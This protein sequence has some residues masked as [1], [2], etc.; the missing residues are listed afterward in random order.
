MEAEGNTEGETEMGL[1]LKNGLAV[2]VTAVP[3]EF[4]DEY[5]AAANGEYVKVYL[6]LLRHGAEELEISRIAD[7]LNHTEA[8]VRRALAYWQ[9]A[10]VLAADDGGGGKRNAEA[11]NGLQVKD[12][13]SEDVRWA[14]SADKADAA[15]AESAAA[16]FGV[17]LS[18]MPQ[19]PAVPAD[20][21]ERLERLS[22]DEEFSTLLYVAQQYL[23]KMF[24]PV[25]CEKFA[26][27]YDI[28][29]LPAE[30]LEYLAEYCAQNGHT[31]IRYI[32]KVALNWYQTGI[33]T[34]Q[35]AED[36]TTRFS[37][38]ISS[39]MKAFGLSSR[40]PGT[41]EKDIMKKWFYTYGFDR[42]LVLEACNRTIKAT[43]TP[44]FQYADKILTGWKEN[45]VRTMGDVEELD[46]KRQLSRTADREKAAGK[47][48]GARTQTARPAPGNRFHNFEG[49]NYNYDEAIW[50]DI[51]KRHKKGEPGDGTE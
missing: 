28:L 21:A 51:R 35:A 20:Q 14:G 48:S 9:R 1:G 5:M 45:G 31:S 11:E 24:T 29:K 33:R 44:S 15:A 37:R 41:T 50:A 3:D 4:I 8:D 46:K 39:V 10:G 19:I 30:L 49:R 43:Q 12:R 27:F 40:N 18:D 6:Y 7:A 36:Y 23:G 2:H 32:E 26:Y 16:D 34:R 47:A 22:G 13:A 38:D 42:P 17:P 25:E